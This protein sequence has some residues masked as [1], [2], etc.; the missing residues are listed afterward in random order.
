MKAAVVAGALCALSAASVFAQQAIP[1]SGERAVSI[2]TR[3]VYHGVDAELDAVPAATGFADLL[4]K[5]AAVYAGYFA[6]NFH[7]R[8]AAIAA[9]AAASRPELIALQEAV[10]V[11]TQTPADG[12]E[13]PATEVALDFVQILLEALSARGLGYEV[14]V[15]S[16]N[17]DAELP[18]A[19]GF[20]VRHTDREVILARS[21]LKTADLKLSNAQGGNFTTNCQIETPALGTLTALRG[22]VS[23]DAKIRGKSFRLISTH[24]DTNC[25]PFTSAI[26]VA[27]TNELLAGPAATELPVILAGDLNSPA[28]GSGASY[29]Q[30][31]ASGFADAAASA[32][33][34]GAATCC[35]DAD[36]L[37]SEPQLTM[38]ID[39]ILFR[40]NFAV[41]A[42]EIVGDE[43]ADR[44]PS[45]LW[46]SDH[47][48]LVARVRLPQP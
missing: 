42:A 20:D 25:L 43:V 23:V 8:A 2:M 11:R 45:G 19:F 36:L 35:H 14:A 47:A 7:E 3:N 18:S 30:L 4:G 34:G 40:G 38:R 13:S 17:F 24:L 26:Q 31:I 5:V 10:L 33:L 6:R 12:P 39:H 29:N 44:T 16:V 27:Q 41:E 48:G 28:G 32:G 15:Q 46:P 9:E 22:W 1:F 37:N 21:D